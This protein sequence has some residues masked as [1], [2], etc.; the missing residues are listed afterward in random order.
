LTQTKAGSRL[1]GRDVRILR[2]ARGQSM[3]DLARLCRFSTATLSLLERDKIE[4]RPDLEIRL[5]KAL[6]G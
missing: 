3:H 6:F 4:M 2:A 1:N 5:V